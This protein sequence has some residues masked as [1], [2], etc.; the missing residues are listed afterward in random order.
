MTSRKRFLILH[1]H[2]YQPPRENP[3][4]GAIQEQGSAYP[5]HDWNERIAAECYTPNAFSRVLDGGGRILKIV[6]NYVS[7]SF[8]VGPTLFSW[9]QRHAPET[10]RR[11]LEANAESMKRLGYGNAI[12]QA[13]HHAIFPL[14]NARDK[15]TEVLWGIEDFKAHFGRDP[16]ALWLPETAVDY[17][18]LRTLAEAGMRFVLLSP[19]QARRFRRL[20]EKTWTEARKGLDPRRPYRCFVKDEEGRTLDQFIDVFFYEPAISRA[21]SFEHLLRNA[22]DLAGRIEAAYL[23]RGEG[24]QV[25]VVATDGETFGHHEPFADMCLAYLFAAEAPKRGITVTNLG[26]YLQG[27]PPAYEVEIEERTAWSCPHQLGRWKED[28]GCSTGGKAGWQQRWRTP[29][30]RGLDRLRDELALI[31]AV[32]GEKLLK[33]IWAARDDYIQVVLNR[34][35]SSVDQFFLHHQVKPLSFEERSRAL[36]LLEMERH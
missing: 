28:C 1:G 5:F 12:A 22:G 29:L 25:V 32:E 35:P 18:T 33:D 2:F 36:R 10:Y 24:D 7:I 26:A 19:S 23:P 21:M 17:P 9:L 30:R 13:Y 11:I 6:N 16:S 27:H 3:W 4:T 34:G 8:N 31:F 14:A 20:G 15:R